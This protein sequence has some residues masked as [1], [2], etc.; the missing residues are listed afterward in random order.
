[1]ASGEFQRIYGLMLGLSA[2]M[3]RAGI[4]HALIGGMA[5]APRGFPRGTRDVDFLIPGEAV[6]ELRE[7]MARRGA[8]TIVE[9]EEFS[10][11]LDGAVRAD[12]QH[13]RREISKSMLERA[14]PVQFPDAVIPVIQVEDLIGLK[15]QA[16]HNNPRRLLDRVDI[17]Q[18]I[19]ANWGK[20]DLDLVRKYFALFRREHE[21][22]DILRLVAASR[23]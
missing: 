7:I 23:R 16:Y 17:Q 1:M 12:F 4:A 9:G 5:L 18:L 19:S 22:D 14:Q 6:Q 2:E 20:M 3:K 21:L 8:T 11:Y 10:S 13:A 15:V